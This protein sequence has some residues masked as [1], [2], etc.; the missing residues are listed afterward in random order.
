MLLKGTLRRMAGHVMVNETSGLL[1][2]EDGNMR[3]GYRHA[4]Q[5]I[6]V[7]TLGFWDRLYLVDCGENDLICYDV[8]GKPAGS[9]YNYLD[10]EIPEIPAID[11]PIEEED[12]IRHNRR[13]VVYKGQ[14]AVVI[15]RGIIYRE[16]FGD[17]PVLEGLDR[18]V[19]RDPKKAVVLVEFW[20]GP[21]AIEHKGA[22]LGSINRDQC[23]LVLSRNAV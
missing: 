17:T 21:I 7:D 4:G 22:S 18:H 8:S 3:F 15:N 2:E 14:L 16:D 19:E 13:V 20:G 1:F 12:V 9:R 23:D 5:R 10:G 11:H 6:C